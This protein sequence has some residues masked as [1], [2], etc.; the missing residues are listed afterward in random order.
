[1]NA[2]RI[3]ALLVEDNPAD[4]RLVRELLTG[5]TVDIVHTT[6]LASALEIL[7]SIKVQVMLLDLMLPD[8]QG[9]ETLIRAQTVAPEL[10]IVVLTGTDDESVA[11][12]AVTSGAQD[13]LVKGSFDEAFLERT[14]HYAI[15]RVETLRKLRI[16]E[17]GRAVETLER[18]L[19]IDLLG[20]GVESGEEIE[21]IRKLLKE[22]QLLGDQHRLPAASMVL[23]Y[24]FPSSMREVASVMQEP[25]RVLVVDDDL[26]TRR[27]I[28]IQLEEEQFIVD[29]AASGQECL[30]KVRQWHPEVIL[31]DVKMPGMDG[32]ETCQQLKRSSET[33]LI[34]VLFITGLNDEKIAINALSAGGSDFVSKSSPTPILCARLRSQIAVYRATAKLHRMSMTDE[35]TGLFSRRFLYESLRREIKRCSRCPTPGLACLLA[36]IDH[37][38]RLNDSLGHFAGDR[39]L[40]DIA[41]TIKESTRETDAAARFGGEEFVIV[42]PGTTLSGARLV[43][44]K[45]RAAVEQRCVVTISIGVAH[46]EQ[47]RAQDLRSSGNVDRM[48]QLLLQQADRAMYTAKVRGRNQVA[49]F[50]ET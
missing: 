3:T 35:L 2:E 37:F 24:D 13:Y 42:I 18:T 14:I 44:E 19:G 26:A 47:V 30:D 33:M 27:L 40:Q 32:I 20:E 6:S 29:T 8:S 46:I 7:G 15:Y 45:V 50:N 23:E 31:L 12:R 22:R 34:P 49:L 39:V 28:Q 48:V 1:M 38:D 25:A 4:A 43:A 9:L 41:T 10:P 16:S 21:R 36:D 17:I 11:R 5:G